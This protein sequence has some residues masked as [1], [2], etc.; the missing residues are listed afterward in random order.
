MNAINYAHR[1]QFSECFSD[2]YGAQQ[3]VRILQ[4][5]AKQGTT[6]LCTIHQPS[7]QVFAMF[8]QVLFLAEGRTAFMGRP[9]EAVAFFAEYVFNFRS[10]KMRKLIHM[11]FLAT[12]FSAHRRIIRPILSLERWPPPDIWTIQ[13]HI[14]WH[15]ESVTHTQPAKYWKRENWNPFP[16]NPWI[17]WVVVTIEFLPRKTK[18]NYPFTYSSPGI[19]CQ[20]K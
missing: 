17:M 6:I 13:T 3:L 7:S 8:H 5:L 14:G 15:I 9:G 19:W 16:K 20:S 4:T 10:K 1:T 12:D 18:M 11:N 2:A